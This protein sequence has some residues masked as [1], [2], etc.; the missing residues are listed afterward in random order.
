MHFDWHMVVDKA[1]LLHY[2]L[3]QVWNQVKRHFDSHS[4][5]IRVV[6]LQVGHLCVKWLLYILLEQDDWRYDWKKQTMNI[7]SSTHQRTNWSVDHSQQTF[8]MYFH[9]HYKTIFVFDYTWRRQLDHEYHNIWKTVEH[10]ARSTLRWFNWITD[11][12]ACFGR[13]FP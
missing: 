1:V 8:L 11:A 5:N 6:F 3:W 10:V 13:S 2:P 12:Q 9:V 7:S 4:C